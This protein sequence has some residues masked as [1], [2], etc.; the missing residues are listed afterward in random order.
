MRSLAGTYVIHRCCQY[1]SFAC[2]NACS[3]SGSATIVRIT[4][5][6]PST[7]RLACLRRKSGGRGAYS[8]WGDLADTGMQSIVPAAPAAVQWRAGMMSPYLS[9]LDSEPEILH[10]P[11]G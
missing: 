11:L 5:V 8:S 4:N 7:C 9:Q 3:A 2:R 6:T 10:L 1:S